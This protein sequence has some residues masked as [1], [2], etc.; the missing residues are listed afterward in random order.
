M[1]SHPLFASSVAAAA[2]VLLL[3]AAPRANGAAGEVG[4]GG[5]MLRNERRM[6]AGDQEGLAVEER[7]EENLIGHRSR[8][9]PGR[10]GG[11]V[12]PVRSLAQL[13]LAHEAL[14]QARR[15]PAPAREVSRAV[16]TTG[17]QL[18]ACRGSHGLV[19]PRVAELLERVRQGERAQAVLL[20]LNPEL[21]PWLASQPRRRRPR[22]REAL[23]AEEPG[24][25]ATLPLM[26]L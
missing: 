18:G 21:M 8:A 15:V 7:L 23:A 3:P 24:R 1:S 19:R 17:S 14:R 20:R 2:L 26:G 25:S 4:V 11:V 12:E 13:A 10:D 22:T 9:E 6:G 5:V 16:R